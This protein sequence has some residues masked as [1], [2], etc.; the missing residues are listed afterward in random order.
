MRDVIASG[1][2]PWRGRSTLGYGDVSTAP[3]RWQS[4]GQSSGQSQGIRA[5]LFLGR[6][7]F[8]AGPVHLLPHSSRSAAGVSPGPDQ[9]FM[10]PRFEPDVAA[11][12]SENHSEILIDPEAYDASEQQFAASLEANAR[13]LNPGLSWR[14][15]QPKATRMDGK[16]LPRDRNHGR[17]AEMKCR[18]P[19]Q[20]EPE[21]AQDPDAGSTRWPRS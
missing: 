16:C 9:S 13:A 10:K 14:M 8:L 17:T 19:A 12:A 5:E 20:A 4:S 21:Q 18:L 2:N 11:D 15:T 6:W 3:A 1:R 7:L